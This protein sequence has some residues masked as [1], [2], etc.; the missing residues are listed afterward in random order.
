MLI[1]D[2]EERILVAVGEY[3]DFQ[4]YD[5]ACAHD[6]PE[7][8][9]L[10]DGRDYAVVIADLRLTGIDASDGL[11]LVTYARARNAATKILLLTAYGTPDVVAEAYR[12]GA[13]AFLAKPHPLPDLA[14][15]VIALLTADRIKGRTNS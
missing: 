7:A 12:R 3:F 5:V 11:E 14:Q 1:V 15:L 6:L 10:L 4:G 8:K 9:A 13:D 2:D